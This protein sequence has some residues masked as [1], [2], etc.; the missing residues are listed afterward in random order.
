[1]LLLKTQPRWDG[2]TLCFISFVLDGYPS[3]SIIARVDIIKLIISFFYALLSMVKREHCRCSCRTDI[4][5]KSGP[6]MQLH[7]SML[8]ATSIEEVIS[9]ML[10]ED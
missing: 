6:P 5:Q 9:T 3:T 4:S 1:V 2:P 7:P 10:E 8:V